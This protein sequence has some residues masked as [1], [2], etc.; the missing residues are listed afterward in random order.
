MILIISS[1]GFI[2][3]LISIHSF[4]KLTFKRRLELISRLEGIKIKEKLEDSV[5]ELD[6]PFF[7]RVLKPIGNNL[8]KLMLRAAPNGIKKRIS[9]KLAM[10]GNPFN[11]GVNEWFLF[12]VFFTLVTPLIFFA[13][14]IMRDEISPNKIGMGILIIIMS[15]YFPNFLLVYMKLHLH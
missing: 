5:D 1:L 4:L 11:I 2:C 12:K 3:I 15:Y 7:E 8:S 6:V 10:A 9:K 14:I 13:D